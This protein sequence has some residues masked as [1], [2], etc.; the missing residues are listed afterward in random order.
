MRVQALAAEAS[1][2]KV[3]EANPSNPSLSSAPPSLWE[4]TRKTLA[5]G[6]PVLR[7]Q[8]TQ[9]IIS[10][11]I[12]APAQRVDRIA[13]LIDGSETPYGMELLG[14]A[15]WAVSEEGVGSDLARII[16]R[17]QSWNARKR[18]VMKP[19]HISAA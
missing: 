18:E 1:K 19:E 8:I 4:T 2:P 5:Q 9:I 16:E 11:R 7:A 15:H 3:R 17:V 14:T 10:R 12:E 6:D 13:R